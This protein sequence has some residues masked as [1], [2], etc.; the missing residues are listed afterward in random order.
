MHKFIKKTGN[1]ASV[2]LTDDVL[3][4]I[5]SL[6]E[7]QKTDGNWNFNEYM[8]G[9]LN[10]MILLESLIYDEDPDFYEEP[11]RFIDSYRKG[12]ADVLT[13]LLE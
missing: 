3:D 13:T 10:G 8:L 2:L 6:M 7:I 4:S 5:D 9:M 1:V 11:Q 12:F